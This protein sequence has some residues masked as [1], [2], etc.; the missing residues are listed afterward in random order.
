MS[1]TVTEDDSVTIHAPDLSLQ[2]KLGPGK[3]LG[4]ILTPP[5]IDKTEKVIAEF[6]PE[7]VKE[8]LAEFSELEAIA[9]K[10][11]PDTVATDELHILVQKGFAIKSKAG[12]CNYS[13]ASS[14]ARFMHLFCESL[15]NKP[16]SLKDTNTIKCFVSI[17]KIIFDRKIVGDGGDSGNV[18]VQE[19]QRMI[20]LHSTPDLAHDRVQS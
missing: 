5:I 7:I 6:E 1:D 20:A 11:M 10:L 16:L 19:A 8:I 4:S 15:L 17:L 12:L 14:L 2:K 9:S 3:S 13:L 18:I